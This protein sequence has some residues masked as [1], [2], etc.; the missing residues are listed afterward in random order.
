MERVFWRLRFVKSR[1]FYK[2]LLAATVTILLGAIRQV[3]PRDLDPLQLGYL[4]G[5]DVSGTTYDAGDRAALSAILL[6]SLL[7]DK[8]FGETID[9]TDSSVFK[10]LDRILNAAAV[11]VAFSAGWNWLLQETANNP[12]PHLV[13]VANPAI[14]LVALLILLI[15]IPITHFYV[16][17]FAQML[18][19][20]LR[21]WAANF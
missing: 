19:R 9:Q 11:A 14:A 6:A 17:R 13:A 12:G 5:I 8:V 3:D 15:L 2:G 7:V 18:W 21:A 10:W 4:F 20:R 16:S 1:A